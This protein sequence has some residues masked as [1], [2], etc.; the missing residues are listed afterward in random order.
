MKNKKNDRKVI[1]VLVAVLLF[2]AVGFAAYTTTLKLG[3]GSS[4][5]GTTATVKGSPWN[6]HYVTN[7]LDMSTGNVTATASN[8][9]TD[10]FTFTVTLS[11]PGDKFIATWNVTNDGSITAYLNA[12][13]MSTLSATQQNYLTYKITYDTTDASPNVFTQSQ[14]GLSNKSLA[15]S[16]TKTIKL[17]LEYNPNVTQANLPSSDDQVTINGSFQYDDAD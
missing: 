7:T 13:T 15:A 10:D 14:S 6:V 2:M 4:G 8:L 12:V 5:T 17:E 16:A 3:G 1:I 9:T 11:K